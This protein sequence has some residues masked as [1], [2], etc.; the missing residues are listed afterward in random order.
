MTDRQV[1]EMLK[2]VEILERYLDA[3]SVSLAADICCHVKALADERDR[4]L[5]GYRQMVQIVSDRFKLHYTMATYLLD[6][7]D[8]RTVHG[9][10]AMCESSRKKTGGVPAQGDREPAPDNPSTVKT[11]A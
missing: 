4:L 11:D 8:L 9:A 5:E 2:D 7:N 6:G 10:E 3:E 1:Q